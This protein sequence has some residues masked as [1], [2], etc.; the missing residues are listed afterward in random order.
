MSN[1]KTYKT[2]KREIFNQ[3]KNI[4]SLTT[5]QLDVELASLTSRNIPNANRQWKIQAVVRLLQHKYYKENKLEIPSVI[6]ENFDSFFEEKVPKNK[7]RKTPIQNNII[8][9]KILNKERIRLLHMI[10]NFCSE[11]VPNGN[12]TFHPDNKYGTVKSGKR[13][14]M[15]VERKLRKIIAFMG[16]ERG[17][18]NRPKLEISIG[19]NDEDTKRAL[20][21]FVNKNLKN[22]INIR[23]KRWERCEFVLQEVVKSFESELKNFDSIHSHPT[24]RYTTF[25]QGR[26]VL[27]FITQDRA[28]GEVSFHPGGE[29]EVNP[30]LTTTIKVSKIKKT[31]SIKKVVKEFIKTHFIIYMN[32]KNKNFSTHKEEMSYILSICKESVNC[33]EIFHHPNNFFG[34]IKNQKRPILMIKR[35]KRKGFYDIVAWVKKQKNNPSITIKID[36]SKKSIIKKISN[37]VKEHLNLRKN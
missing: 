25:K 15:F 14:I 21:E 18:S 10:T 12:V 31:S 28:K 20:T 2:A 36:N 34:L 3:V 6:Q 5:K 27:V 32:S 1:Q 16:G 4:P 7:K 26:L 23:N 30:N 37:L 24:G 13:V 11:I 19:V 33:D 8:D 22:F 9:R 17:R 29:R 35:S